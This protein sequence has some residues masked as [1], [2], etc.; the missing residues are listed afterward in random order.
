LAVEQYNIVA[1]FFFVGLAFLAL[2][3]IL[4]WFLSPRRPNPNKLST[5]ECG[6]EP[7][8]PSW[9]QFNIRYYIFALLFVLFDIEVVFVFP[10]ALHLSRTRFPFAVLIDMLV[11]LVILTVGLVYAWR[12]GTLTW[13]E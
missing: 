3:L 10:W 9:G 11:F 1:V 12:K 2:L 13:E 7:V 8:G 6:N 5:Y 4:S